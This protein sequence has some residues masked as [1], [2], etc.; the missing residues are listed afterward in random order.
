[1]PAAMRCWLV[2]CCKNIPLFDGVLISMGIGLPLFCGATVVL[3]PPIALLTDICCGHHLE[4]PYL[5]PFDCQQTCQP[6]K[7]DVHVQ[8]MHL[9]AA[10]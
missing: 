8:A 3:S 7:I 10:T 6:K 1:M 5:H 9:Y 2:C 4:Q